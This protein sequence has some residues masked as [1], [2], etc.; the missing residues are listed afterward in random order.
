MSDWCI[1]RTKGSNTLR[2][3]NSLNLSH[4]EAWTPTEIH[5]HR[6]RKTRARTEAMVPVMPTYVFAR[7]TC[8]PDLVELS[9]QP[10][11]IHPGFSVFR[12][13]D[14]FPVVGDAE[15][16]ALRSIERKAAARHAPVVFPAGRQVR[17]PEGPFAGLTGQVVETSKGEFT[18]V[19]FPGFN[20]PV[21]FASWKLQEAA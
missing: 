14:R 9:L 16:S 3:S 20:I 2:L 11:S 13:L 18:L 8:L 5:V 12:Y 4:I 17:V 21:K 6:D 15:L 7:A 1:L 19:A 10:V